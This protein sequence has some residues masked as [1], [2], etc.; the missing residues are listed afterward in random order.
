MKSVLSTSSLW[1]FPSLSLSLPYLANIYLL[2]VDN[3]NPITRCG[4]AYNEYMPTAII[5]I[6]DTVFTALVK[7]FLRNILLFMELLTENTGKVM[8][9]Y[10]F[11]QK[12]TV[13]KTG[14]K[15]LCHV[16]LILLYY[17][18]DLHCDMSGD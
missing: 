6:S 2:K 11:N 3:R 4:S 10:L 9:S 14:L 17:R 5:T 7:L 15:I 16:A 13:S 12:F 18:Y 1:L 8:D